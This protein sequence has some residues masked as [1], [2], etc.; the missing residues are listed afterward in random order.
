MLSGAS[1]A[2]ITRRQQKNNNKV[3]RVFVFSFIRPWQYPLPNSKWH[4]N[5]WEGGYPTP[6]LPVHRADTKPISPQ[7][8]WFPFRR[9]RAAYPGL[10]CS[11]RRHI[12]FIFS[13]HTPPRP[14]VV[15][16][17]RF[18]RPRFVILKSLAQGTQRNT[19]IPRFT[20]HNKKGC[21]LGGKQGTRASSAA[22]K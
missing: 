16:C 9:S 20:L 10:G 14:F 19:N 12:Y 5:L 2:S 18:S 11:R 15:A 17:S 21:D 1:L 8:L 6:S 4:I 3:R 7:T 22:P 13:C